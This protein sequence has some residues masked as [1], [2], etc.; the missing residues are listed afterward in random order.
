M[1]SLDKLIIHS[2]EA[3]TFKEFSDIIKKDGNIVNLTPFVKKVDGASERHIAY[4]GGVTRDGLRGK[5]T[6]NA[7]QKETLEIYVKYMIRRHP[8]LKIYGRGASFNVSDWLQKIGL[9]RPD[10]NNAG[11]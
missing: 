2:T 3:S 5:D 11:S 6:R 8:G 4:V 1:A 9:S 10:N 7:L